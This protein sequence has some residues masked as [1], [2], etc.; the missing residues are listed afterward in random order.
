MLVLLQ[1]V[2]VGGGGGAEGGGE[3]GVD[4]VWRGGGG[5]IRR[6]CGCRCGVTDHQYSR[7]TTGG[8][9]PASCSRRQSRRK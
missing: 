5:G 6:G 3:R 8:R 7:K 2:C 9:E 4:T 1:R